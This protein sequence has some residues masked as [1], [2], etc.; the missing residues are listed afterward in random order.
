MLKGL[1]KMEMPQKVLF[2]ILLVIL[3]VAIFTPKSSTLFSPL[4]LV[5][6]DTLKPQRKFQR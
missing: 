1:E 3:I 6:K 5:F 4:V 2:G